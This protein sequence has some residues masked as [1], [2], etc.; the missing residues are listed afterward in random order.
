MKKINYLV[1]L[2]L[3]CSLSAQGVFEE[4]VESDETDTEQEKLFDI[5]GYIRGAYFAGKIPDEM[6][7]ET[8]SAYGDACLKVSAGKAA[9]GKSFAEIRFTTGYESDSIF[10][11]F[12]LREA[13]GS[14][15][16]G[17]FDFYLGKQIIDV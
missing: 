6:K 11:R 3:F 2:F 10:S 5:G 13:Y 4:A 12:E 9:Y 8:K 14:L 7:P 16:A 17:P 15:V 1:V